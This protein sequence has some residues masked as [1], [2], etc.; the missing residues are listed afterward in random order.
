MEF[1]HES[2]SINPGPA[3]EQTERDDHSQRELVPVDAE[4]QAG[5]KVDIFLPSDCTC[6]QRWE[7]VHQSSKKNDD[8]DQ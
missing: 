7:N 6:K 5:V 1:F 2:W 4:F 3:D 8:Y